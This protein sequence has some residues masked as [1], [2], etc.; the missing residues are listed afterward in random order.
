MKK[1]LLF[2]LTLILSATL[3]G[4]TDSPSLQDSASYLSENRYPA[5]A[6]RPEDREVYRIK[7]KVD[8]PVT[9]VGMGWSLYAFTKI[10]SKDKSTAAE[11]L[12]LDKNDLAS[13]NRFGADVYHPQAAKTSDYIFYGSM[14]L[15]LLLLADKEIRKDAG[16]IG[17]LY[18]E[19]MAIT[20]L[21][22]TGATFF[23]DKYRPYA[24]NPETPLEKR[25][26][27]GAKNS[28]FA[29][30]VALVGTSTFFIAKVYSDYHPNSSFRHVLFGLATAA[31][32]STAY[33]RYRSGQ[34]FFDDLVIGTAI[35]TLTGIL[36]PKWHKNPD[37]AKTGF[38][39]MPYYGRDKGLALVYRF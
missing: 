18:L 23:V 24:Y 4:Q 11:V 17:F 37:Q 6:P 39:L 16:K 12:A 22:Y 13:Y 20:G 1:Q 34:H 31:T 25:M 21:L 38:K 3:F 14:P 2:C 15:P 26:G 8:I 5:S 29:G 9:A 10:Y 32:A 19:S 27:G 30:H 33:L 35:G 28:F 7:K 36:V